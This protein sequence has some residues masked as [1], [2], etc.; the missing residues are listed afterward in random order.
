MKQPQA[1][2]LLETSW[3]VCNKV[4]GIY[5]VLS[6]KSSYMQELY[7]E[8]R[9]IGPYKAEKAADNFEAQETP[10]KY[11]DVEATLNERGIKLHFGK[12]LVN[13]HPDC[14]LIE[15][16][17]LWNNLD[18]YKK[19]LWDSHRVDSL[20][21][22]D[23]F[24]EPLLF[25]MA[26]AAFIEET[27]RQGAI[28]A[29]KTV[30]H[31]HEWLTGFSV[32]KLK[33]QDSHVSTTFTTHATMLG[34]TISGIEGNLY[35]RLDEIDAESKAKE[36]G[37]MDKH[38]AE[39][40]AAKAADAFT[41]V[42]KITGRECTAL[43]GKTPD[44]YVLNGLDVEHFPSFEE[45]SIKHQENRERIREF[46]SY[47][48]YPHYT[49]DT[50]HNL[51][52]LYAGRYEYENK[53][54]DIFLEALSR[55]NEELR[56]KDT[57][58]TVSVFL[59]LAAPNNGPKYEL[60][61][62]KNIY[63]HLQEQLESNQDEITKQILYDVISGEDRTE[64]EL[65]SK[66][67]LQDMKRTLNRFKQESQ[68]PLCSHELEGG[69]E[70]H[71][72]IQEMR[73]LGLNNTEDD[74]VKVMLYP[75]YLDGNDSLLNLKY[76]DMISGSHLGVFPSYYEPWGY[77]P[78]E[79]AAMAVPAV[80]TDLAGY[81]IY[82]EEE[83]KDLTE[84]RGGVYVVERDGKSWQHSADDLHSVLSHYAGLSHA[85]RVKEKMRAKMLSEVADW[86][87]FQEHYVEAHNHAMQN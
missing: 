52:M 54:I 45:A 64:A 26:V 53:G 72:I 83:L 56:E 59:C 2:T 27:E 29:E 60:L 23:D 82:M 4:G 76:F 35:E 39:Q 63:Q 28:P 30:F 85:D 49:F 67:E 20:G 14:V 13:Q 37:V 12:W 41:T 69:E 62:S 38:S 15:Y 25:S 74:P 70:N 42:S 57:E 58:R 86:Q 48:F 75:A 36:L 68:P 21:S 33:N 78:L 19:E 87:E 5:S 8:Y 46:L 22:G 31:A 73:R 51:T 65:L 81:G 34:R 80:T 16:D 3:E 9:A 11:K 55:L 32:L 1:T 79:T 43:H 61:K 18:D 66:A 50:S 40:A 6:S 77:T 84:E 7:D 17:G 47:A 71:R 24:N 44:V 10:K